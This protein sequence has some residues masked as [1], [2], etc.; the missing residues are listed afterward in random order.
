MSK[1]RLRGVIY[2]AYCVFLLAS[3][4]EVGH[5]QNSAATQSVTFEGL[6]L[7]LPTRF[8]ALPYLRVG[9]LTS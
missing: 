8:Q 6:E 7:K 2:V 1:S 3:A 5:A 4:L 9:F